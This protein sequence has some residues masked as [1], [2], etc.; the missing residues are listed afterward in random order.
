MWFYSALLLFSV[1]VPVLFSFDNRLKF[2]R[3]LNYI[4]PSMI[5]VAIFYLVFDVH[6]TKEG[7]WGFNPDYHLPVRIFHLPP[8]EWLFF[9]A[10]PYAC[11]FL[12]DSVMM[13]FPRFRLSRKTGRSIT[14]ILILILSV[15]TI[16]H[17]DKTYTVYIFSVTIMA[18]ILSVFDKSGLINNYYLTFLI[19][20]IPFIL[21]DGILTGSFFNREV[22]WYNHEENLNIRFLTIPVEDFAYAFSLIFY[23]LLLSQELRSRLT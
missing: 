17:L 3:R 2:Y 12:H 21:V 10:I 11:L 4:V 7:I 13:H 20:L 1:I 23:N 8:E 18:L 15:T 9:L 14:W 6:F 22:V 16:T 5:I 19:I